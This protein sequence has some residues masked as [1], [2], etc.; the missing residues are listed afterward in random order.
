MRSS[1]SRSAGRPK[2]TQ[3]GCRVQCSAVQYGERGQCWVLLLRCS[4]VLTIVGLASSKM[5]LR[6]TEW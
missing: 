5:G 2:N 3:R 4:Q 6:W 1:R